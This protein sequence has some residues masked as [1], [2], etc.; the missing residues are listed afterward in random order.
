MVILCQ[1][2]INYCVSSK[3][4]NVN[5]KE[6]VWQKQ[7]LPCFRIF[8]HLDLWFPL[9]LWLFLDKLAEVHLDVEVHTICG[10]VRVLA[11]PT[12]DLAQRLAP[13]TESCD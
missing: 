6:F 11:S 1:E 2:G 10:V 8:L 3:N 13:K 5:V 12:R 9:H 7:Q 4:K